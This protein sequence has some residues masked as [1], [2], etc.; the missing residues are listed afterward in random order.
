[1]LDQLVGEQ[2]S[3]VIF[4]QDYIQ[5]DFDDHLLTVY[6]WPSV[7]CKT[8]IIKWNESGFRDGLCGRIA[9]RVISATATKGDSI[10]IEFDDNCK[11]I[12]SLA[13]NDYRGPEAAE[14][15][16]KVGSPVVMIF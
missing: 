11:I 8:G 15:R 3:A 12:I 7:S 5:F 14:L 4:V 13:S 1:M 16:N 6:N 9:K 2:L 10:V